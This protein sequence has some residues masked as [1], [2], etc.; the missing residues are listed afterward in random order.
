ML[1]RATPLPGPS[2]VLA[3]TPYRAIGVLGQGGMGEAVEAEHRSLNKRVVVKLLR[4]ELSSDPRFCDRLRVEA[5]A[6]AAL[7]SP[8]VVSVTDLGQTPEGRPYLV[9]ERLRGRTLREELDRRGA[10]P[11]REAIPILRQV[12]AG[13]AAAH[14][15]G[16]IHRDVK[17]ENVFLCDPEGH[18]VPIV[19]VL[20]FGIAKIL[21]QGGAPLPFSAPQYPTEE[22]V[23]VGSPRS[24]S[25]E[26]ARFQC[27]DARTD[28]YAAGLLLYTLIVGRGPFAHANDM[29]ALLNAHVLE[30]PAPPSRCAAQAIPR[31]LDE[32]ILRALAK[33]PDH[34]FQSAE[35][36]AAELS[37]IEQGLTGEETALASTAA[38]PPE[39]TANGT[40]IL[41]LP[42]PAVA[43]PLEHDTARLVELP[44][45]LTGPTLV[46]PGVLGGAAL[47]HRRIGMFLMLTLASTLLFSAL[48]VLVCRWL[49]G[50]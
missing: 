37:R 32:A 27:V 35:Q 23:L 7:S 39:Q 30:P 20:D 12:L 21:H 10:F 24:V 26:Q 50:R 43:V 47:K 49:E 33:R 14:R 40:W 38:A 5:Q 34:R 9:M 42:P 3:G 41:R 17:P 25:P 6:M 13:L 16:I 4:R 1:E 31:A 19:K 2:D 44:L 29:L 8:Y 46:S 18:A 28:V 11:L 15:V 22:G 36:F 45:N 48:T